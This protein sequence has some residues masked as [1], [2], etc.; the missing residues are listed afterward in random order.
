LAARKRGVLI[1]CLLVAASLLAVGIPV[2][3]IQPFRH[4]TPRDLELSYFL[5][6]WS[7]VGVSILAGFTLLW[8]I[9]LWRG[10]PGILRRSALVLALALSLFSA[11]FANQ[12]HFEWMFRPPVKAGFSTPAEAS[13]LK[14]EDRVLGVE[15]NGEA[16]AYPIRALAYHHLVH[17]QVGGVDVVVTY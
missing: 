6:R 12:N 16:A 8:V 1:L 17:D 5:R 11:W 7:P 13:F 15:I 10:S 4:Q 9:R 14:D 3:L 2:W